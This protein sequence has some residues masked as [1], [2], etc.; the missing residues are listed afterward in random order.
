VFDRFRKGHDTATKAKHAELEGD[1]ARAA[2]LWADAGRVDEAARVMLLRGDAEG[3]PAKRRQHYVQA[4]ALAEALPDDAPVK[5][6]A[7]KK[8]ATL[9][10][11][12]A[13]DGAGSAAA[14]Q[15]LLEAA[16]DLEALGE[17]AFAAEAYGLAGDVEGQARALVLAGDVEAVEDVLERD[18]ARASDARRAERT[19]AETERLLACGKRRE[20]LAIADPATVADVSARR[21]TG[22]RFLVEVRGAPVHLVLG[23]EVV[24]GRGED[25]DVSLRIASPAVSR[26][27]VAIG[28]DAK[29]G[30]VLRDLGSRNGTVLRGMRVAGE[31]PIPREGLEVKLGGE[32]PLR[33]APRAA[34]EPFD[35]GASIGIAGLDLVAPLGSARLGPWQLEAASD[36]WI[37]LVTD[38]AHP[39]FLHGP[40]GPI[41]VTART[42][43]LVGDAFAAARDAVVLVRA[44]GGP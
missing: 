13:R 21:V 16:Q 19:H 3:D 29:G 9:A 4:V 7:K 41:A 26:R 22:P 27:H 35:G 32:V 24:I 11:A 6:L 34:G 31:L 14:R 8:R 43:L 25:G 33:V 23:D 36:G 2:T 44:L 18:R 42:P 37:E 1:L 28:R 17:G 15:D 20:A 10:I 40:H 5:R 39:C 30:L 38:G 12:S